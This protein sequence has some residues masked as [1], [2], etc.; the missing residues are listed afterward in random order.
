MR[1]IKQKISLEQ[2]KSRMPGVIPAYDA[3]DSCFIRFGKETIRESKHN[4]NYGM[5]PSDVLVPEEFADTITDYTDYCVTVKDSDGNYIYPEDGRSLE[6]DGAEVKVLTYPTL[7]K[8]YHFFNEYEN[9][10][11]SNKCKQPYTSATEYFDY[12]VRFGTDHGREYYEELDRIYAARGGRAFHEWISENCFPEYE[13]PLEFRDEWGCRVLSYPNAVMWES[14][15]SIRDEYSACTGSVCC[16]GTTN[17]C[18]CEEYVRRGGYAFYQG[19]SEWLRSVEAKMQENKD[20]GVF[21]ETACMTLPV[22]MKSRIEDLGEMDNISEDWV[23]GE[24]YNAGSVVFAP[25]IIDEDGTIWYDNRGF[26][27]LNGSAYT[28]DGTFM[29]IDFNSED[30]EDTLVHYINEHRDEFET[31]PSTFSFNH[32]GAIIFNPDDEKMSVPY[33]ADMPEYGVIAY[34]GMPY[35]VVR[36]EYVV[37]DG[38]LTPLNG[39]VCIVSRVGGIPFVVIGGRRFLAVK[40]ATGE[41]VFYFSAK[42]C[43]ED[44]PGTP[45]E[46]GPVVHIGGAVYAV[47][48]NN[49]K[50]YGDRHSEGGYTLYPRFD[51]SVRVDGSI[52]FIKD[53][54]LYRE[55]GFEYSEGM[56]VNSYIPIDNKDYGIKSYFILDGIMRITYEYTVYSTEYISGYTESYIDSIK[57]PEVSTDDMG[58]ALPGRYIMPEDENGTTVAYAQPAEGD[59]LD[60]YY[61]VG[62]AR[63][64]T[65]FEY[66]GQTFFNGSIIN[67]MK[68]Y[69]RALDGSVI[70]ETL[71]E[72]DNTP[73]RQSCVDAIKDCE[74]RISE[75]MANTPQ[76]APESVMT[77]EAEYYMGALLEYDKDSGS[78]VLKNGGFNPMKYIEYLR[79]YP[80]ECL[81]YLDYNECYT[82]K[83]YQPVS[84][85]RHVVMDDLG[86]KDVTVPYSI[87][88]KRVL[89]WPD[90]TSTQSIADET[91]KIMTALPVYRSGTKIGKSMVQKDTSDIY[92]DR[93]RSAAFERHLKLGE[94]VTME[95]LENYGNGWFLMLTNS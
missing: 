60:L 33:G 4:G 21:T 76:K 9:L 24:D 6:R 27:S 88:V 45:I 35:E 10:I 75:Y 36:T 90:G 19:L 37:Y 12:E 28:F 62:V 39:T 23:P 53:G 44:G 95:A 58:N 74:E 67:S 80:K 30:W 41:Y 2:F 13:I 47:T 85:T 5:I 81:Y 63:G 14:W 64:L 22:M 72:I 68:F 3:D 1:V 78:Y 46:T 84:D 48:E 52:F 73:G 55:N 40:N 77:M 11:Q 32:N 83:Y 7:R 42:P 51:G 59:T 70:D 54:I 61:E 25:R 65:P 92:I 94:V 31:N 66:E 56:S 71:V 16:R 34:N 50:L 89:L 57:V 29:E 93:G 26:I 8:W 69:Y 91:G 82:L 87:F 17:C 49:V 79:L 43:V 86:G 20:S 18:D 15:F 38:P